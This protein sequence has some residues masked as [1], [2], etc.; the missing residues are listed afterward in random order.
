MEK[1]N[2]KE[3]VLAIACGVLIAKTIY[4]GIEVGATFVTEWWINRKLKKEI[5]ADLKG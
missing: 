3:D 2:F 4:Y 5:E 1:N